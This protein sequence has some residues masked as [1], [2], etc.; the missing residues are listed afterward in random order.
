MQSRLTEH[1]ERVVGFERVSSRITRPTEPLNKLR[2]TISALSAF[3]PRNQ[4]SIPSNCSDISTG[5]NTCDSQCSIDTKQDDAINKV[6]MAQEVV[7]ERRKT[8]DK[9]KKKV[10]TRRQSIPAGNR[11]DSVSLPSLNNGEKTTGSSWLKL[12]TV[13]KTKN[14]IQGKRRMSKTNKNSS[15]SEQEEALPSNKLSFLD[16]E[17]VNKVNSRSIRSLDKRIVSRALQ[18]NHF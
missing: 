14:N 4:V 16:E 3:K 5:N 6:A 17:D 8:P 9:M 10:E 1:Q 13:L 18:P 7:P 12:R 15:D 11:K 2:L